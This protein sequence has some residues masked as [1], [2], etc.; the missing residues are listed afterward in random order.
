MKNLLIFLMLTSYCS[1]LSASDYLRGD[2]K[3][4]QPYIPLT[5]N[6]MK[7][8]AGY[9]VI[10][11]NGSENDFLMS[12]EASFAKSMLHETF[13]NADGLAKMNHLDLLLIPANSKTVLGPG[14]VHIMFFQLNE[15]LQKDHPQKALLKFQNA[16]DISIEFNIEKLVQK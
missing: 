6:S 13:I 2:I 12:V 4:K 1:T 3:I 14:G 8:A 11:N 5:S 10:E 15:K 7:T 16:G 9:L